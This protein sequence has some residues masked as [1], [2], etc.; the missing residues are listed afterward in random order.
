LISAKNRVDLSSISEVR[1]YITEW[2]RFFGPPCKSVARGRQTSG[3]YSVYSVLLV[4]TRGHDMLAQPTPNRLDSANF[5]YPLS[6]S[7]LVRGDPLRI[8]GKALRF[9]KLESSRQ[10]MVKFW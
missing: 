3:G 8:Y 9:L 10:P 6:F 4:L 7:A 1:S 2:P 5:P